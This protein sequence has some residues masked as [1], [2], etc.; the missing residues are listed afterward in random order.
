VSLASPA[1][2]ILIREVPAEVPLPVIAH[3]L[4]FD[5][6][7]VLTE[8]FRSAGMP[9]IEVNRKALGVPLLS[10]PGSPLI[11]VV[12]DWDTGA[13][14]PHFGLEDVPEL[15]D[16]LER[17]YPREPPGALEVLV[18]GRRV[19]LAPDAE[20]R[21]ASALAEVLGPQPGPVELRLS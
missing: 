14:A 15:A 5:V 7:L 8:G 2:L 12:A 16:F 1:E 19:A 21:L 11:A 13:V 4:L 3:R 17:R 10:A 6:D 9:T 18:D 20:A